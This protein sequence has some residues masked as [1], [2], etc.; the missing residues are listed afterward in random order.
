M[1]NLEQL[2]SE[3][4]EVWPAAAAGYQALEGVLTR[5]V[6]VDD[7]PIVL[8]HNPGRIRST[9]AKVSAEEIKKRPCFLCASH[10]P[11]EQMSVPFE[12]SIDYEILVNPYPIA[13]K[14]F[15][16]A[17]RG[18]IAQD[19]L[20][21]RD[22]A[23]FTRTYPEYVA[24]F[25]G[26]TAG[27]SAPDHLHFQA[28]GRDFPAALLSFL[29]SCPGALVKHHSDCDIYL[30]E[31][32]MPAILFRSREVTTD[33]LLWLSRLLPTD[34]ATLAPAI[35]MRNIL[36]WRD[37][38]DCLSTLMFPRKAHRPAC[39]FA[40]DENKMLIS[41]G[42]LDMAGVV[43]LPRRED[44]DRLSPMMLRHVYD[45]VSYQFIDSPEF[46]QLLLL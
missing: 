29:D 26:S 19:K 9:A 1:N 14:H 6:R 30:P 17:A 39:Y 35:G 42:A 44:F 20:D 41:P 15:T 45:Q 34:S 24:F 2:L 10:R 23:L 11:P 12:A 32:P 37:N 46:R 5:T 3:Q 22:M 7:F 28:C 38:H 27:A 43:I 18:H 8:Q 16:V 31:L 21:V 4:L 40:G 36:M 25:N 33:M 13:P